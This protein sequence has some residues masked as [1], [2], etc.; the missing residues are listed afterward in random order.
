MK[1]RVQWKY[2]N[3]IV[4]CN[5]L[6]DQ[7][8]NKN[9]RLYDCT[10]YLHY[11]DN[12]PKK[13]YDVESGFEDYKNAHIPKAAFLDLQNSLSEENSPYSFTLPTLHELADRFKKLGI[14]LPFHIILYAQN[15][16][17]WATRVWWM[18]RA[19]GFDNA[20]VLNGNLVEW[21]RLGLSIESGVNIFSPA[22]FKTELRPDIF[23]DKTRVLEAMQNNSVIEL[24][25]LTQELHDGKNPRY[26]RRGRIP[27]SLN[28]PFHDLVE[29]DSG[30]LKSPGEVKKIFVNKGIT[31]GLEVVNYCGGGIAAT[32][33]AFVLWQLGFYK[34]QLYDNSMSEWAMD[35]TLPIEKG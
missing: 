30:K 24:N 1:N 28:V 5:W 13:P 8:E 17:Q 16:M 29:K 7:I 26:G 23:V 11:T 27:N 33:D 10:T 6:Q 34:L 20:S 4:E 19:V 25:A 32:L 2:P 12:H 31:E 14:G 22:N 15:G 3:A 21:K 35:D 18:L 9:I